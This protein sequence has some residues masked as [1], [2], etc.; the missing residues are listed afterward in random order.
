MASTKLASAAPPESL[1]KSSENLCRLCRTFGRTET[2]VK[3]GAQ[4]LVK[5]HA[6]GVGFVD[7]L[8]SP[9]YIES[10]F[11]DHY[12]TDDLRLEQVYGEL[13]RRALTL[14]AAQVHRRKEQGRI[15]DVGCAGGFFL[16]RYFPSAQWEKFGVEPSRYALG[17]AVQRGIQTYEGDVLSVDLPAKYF[18]V[19]TVAGVLPYFREPRQELHAMR[20]AL[21]SDGLLVLELPLGGTQ[22][23]R[24][25]TKTGRLTGGGTRSIFDSPHLYF[26]NLASLRLLLRETRFCVQGLY[27]S[28]GNQQAGAMSDTLFKAYYE[29]S[30]FVSWISGG[31]IMLGPGIV[32]CASQVCN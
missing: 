23:W 22:V 21:K 3:N 30:R 5:C 16:D 28:P 27:P 13:R 26:Y 15:L 11:K 32:I 12:I 7:P 24:H 29:G 17:R 31:G 2:A 9:S 19:I 20:R 6:C 10:H 18:D 4:R 25:T 1:P 14:V 8:P